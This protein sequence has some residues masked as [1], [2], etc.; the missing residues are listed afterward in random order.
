MSK[1]E[2]RPYTTVQITG[3]FER[4]R[5]VVNPITTEMPASPEEAELLLT[6][7]YHGWHELT[8]DEWNHLAKIRPKP[9]RKV[10]R[11]SGT[12]MQSRNVASVFIYLRA[13][14]RE[15]VVTNEV[16]VSAIARWLGCAE[17]TVRDDIAIAKQFN[18]GKWWADEEQRAAEDPQLDMWR[19][20]LPTL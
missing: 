10:G 3:T 8:D 14:D 6:A 17:R 16:I 18:G 19:K 1:G 15:R 13:C 20:L 5:I 9:T 7:K 2:K 4:P 12:K 11:P